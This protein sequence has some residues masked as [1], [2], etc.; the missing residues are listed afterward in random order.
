[1]SKL[2]LTCS[3]SITTRK[4][5]QSGN[6]LPQAL[7]RTQ[8]SPIRS[9]RF[10]LNHYTYC[11]SRTL[12]LR[13]YRAGKGS[14]EHFRN[15]SHLTIYQTAVLLILGPSQLLKCQVK[16]TICLPGTWEDSFLHGASYPFA[17]KCKSALSTFHINHVRLI[18]PLNFTAELEQKPGDWR[19]RSRMIS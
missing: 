13:F 6:T 4:T 14:P 16:L 18:V 7:S 3:N 2:N 17:S 5:K 10:P 12:F 1:M 15:K 11:F 19:R 9:E 8:F